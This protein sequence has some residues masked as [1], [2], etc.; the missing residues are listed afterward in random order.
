MANSHPNPPPLTGA[1][2]ALG[3][4]SVGLAGFMTVLDS[5]I[6]N[7][8]IPTISGNL[9]VSVDEG[10]WV[11]TVFAAANAISIPL[12]GWLTQRLGQVRLFAGSILLFVLASWLCGIAP[13]LP[14]LLVARIFQGAMA[15]PLIPM[16]QA[17]LLSSWPK[18][19]LSTALK[20]RIASVGAF[21]VKCE[22]DKQARVRR[23]G[24]LSRAERSLTSACTFDGRGPRTTRMRP[25]VIRLGM[26]LKCSGEETFA[27][28]PPMS[29][30][31][32]RTKPLAR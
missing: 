14:I 27:E 29:L 10:T 32:R 18:S 25:L 31:G 28:L 12:T 23:H 20:R 4:L 11:I 6:A 21:N 8:A 24:P 2:L 7:V 13:S 16:S 19:K 22:S 5:S 26:C 15:G 30:T 3:S 1:T 9:G 17:L